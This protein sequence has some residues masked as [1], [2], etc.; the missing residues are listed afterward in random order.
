MEKMLGRG[1]WSL[2]GT[3][4]PAGGTR[5]RGF[6]NRPYS[7]FGP[8]GDNRGTRHP[9]PPGDIFLLLH[10]ILEHKI[11]DPA[12]ALAALLSNEAVVDEGVRQSVRPAGLEVAL[13]APV[14]P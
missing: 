9:A 14:F 13:V 4:S 7:D 1:R 8:Y 3:A 2:V 10:A 12:H 5:W 6:R 11:L